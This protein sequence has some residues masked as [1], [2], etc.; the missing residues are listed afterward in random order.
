MITVVSVCSVDPSNYKRPVYSKEWVDKLY[1]GVRRNLDIPF[2]FVC[3]SNDFASCD[4]EVAPLTTNSWGWWN[5]LDMF[6][7]NLFTGPCLYIDIDNVIC[8]NITDAIANLPSN[9]MLMPIEPYNNILNSSV[10]FWNGNYSHLYHNYV[11]NQS[12]I[13]EQYRLPTPQQ[14]AIGDQGFI[15][16]NT[17]VEAFNNYVDQNFFGWKHHIVGEHINDPAI[18]IFTSTEKPTNNQ[19]L[20]LVKNNWI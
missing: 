20:E 13:V 18:L 9:K 7:A 16:D 10:I 4:Y 19:H 14:P 6:R 2:R 1:R 17:N 12:R 3:L 5:K 15:R 8:K 11:L